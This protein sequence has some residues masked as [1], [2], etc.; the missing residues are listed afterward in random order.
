[1]SFLCCFIVINYLTD[2][3]IF[4][5]SDIIEQIYYTHSQLE[6]PAL[7]E[8]SIFPTSEQSIEYS[9]K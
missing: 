9:L 6:K 2:T 8:K 4:K 5:V 1:M 3:T 7:K